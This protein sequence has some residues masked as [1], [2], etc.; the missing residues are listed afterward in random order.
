MDVYANWIDA[1]TK[2]HE[3]EVEPV[4]EESARQTVRKRAVVNDDDDDGVQEKR[5]SVEYEED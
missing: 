3:A 4:R 1:N 2:E 5:D